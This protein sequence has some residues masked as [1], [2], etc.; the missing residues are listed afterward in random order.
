MDYTRGYKSEFYASLIDP[1]SWADTERVEIISG[2]VN[3]TASGLRQT[4]SIKVRD[5]DRTHEHW[6][7]VYMDARQDEDITHT[8]LFTGIAAAPKE[9]IDGM[10]ATNELSCYSVLE[11]LDTPILIGTYIPRGITADKAIR[12]LL[13]ATPA[14]VD[15]A[16]NTPRLE[17]YIVAE[18]NETSLTLLQKVLDAIAWQMY[19]AGDGTI[20][21]RPKPEEPAAAFSAVNADVL[22]T[23]L[24]KTRD[25][26]KAPNVF[27]ATSGDAVAVARDDD[28]DS[29]LSTV[30][31]GRDVVMAERDVTLGSG[32]GLAEYAR[33]R[34]AEEQQ[35]A[36]TADYTRRF[37]PD[38]HVGDMVTI[39]YDQ[40][41]GTYEVTQQT[42]NLT[43]N[44]QT[45]EQ[46]ERIPGT[47][48]DSILPREEWDALVLPD[49][50]YLIMPDGAMLL[51]PVK[52]V[53]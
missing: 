13:T 20:V 26:F 41:Q 11:P 2:S 23:T 9:D 40:I 22:E 47:E 1:V 21:I 43:Y 51:V 15:I 14:P 28:P 31:R 8:A 29:P 53:N 24:S 3:N 19:I 16:E 18:D 30:A 39:N 4:A 6:I 5:F 17:D 35:V 36:E 12:Q 27:R 44:G 34:L 37:M 38:V 45:Q 48:W 32:E 46:V 10:V 42:V 7:R 25:W 49:D 52:T 50:N 33:R